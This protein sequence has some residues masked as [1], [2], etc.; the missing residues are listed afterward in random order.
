MNSNIK[1][2]HSYIPNCYSLSMVKYFR[3][4]ACLSDAFCASFSSGSCA[5]SFFAGRCL[6]KPEIHSELD[7]YK[8]DDSL[9]YGSGSVT[10]M[11]ISS[12][13]LASVYVIGS[14]C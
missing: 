8:R 13:L 1:L 12:T 3:G 9:I 7:D 10:S 2:Q 14:A 6:G 11:G 5:I 4:F